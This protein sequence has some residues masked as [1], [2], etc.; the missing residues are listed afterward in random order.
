MFGI[1][2]FERNTLYRAGRGDVTGVSVR[3]S[4]FLQKYA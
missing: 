2:Y 3:L 1:T 4:V